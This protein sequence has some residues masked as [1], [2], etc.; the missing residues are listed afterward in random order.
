MKI[1][2]SKHKIKSIPTSKIDTDLNIP[3]AY[4]SVD[5]SKY[6]IDK[7][8]DPKFSTNSK[9]IL[10]PEQELDNTDFLLFNEFEEVVNKNNLFVSSNNKYTFYPSNTVKFSPRK[11]LWS[12]TVKKNL[13]YSISTTYNIKIGY[14]ANDTL[15]RNLITTFMN[16]SERNMLVY[17]NIKINS[18][19][20]QYDT[21]DVIDDSDADIMFIKSHNCKHYDTNNAVEID[22]N[23]FL[24]HHTNIWFGCEDAVALQE[25]YKMLMATVPYEFKISEPLVS[26]NGNI[27]SSY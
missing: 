11:F 1:Y 13:Q 2:P 21:F 24:D 19:D 7:I 4:V 25:S 3:L 27:E 8:I 15:N 22:I 20:K 23:G 26:E 12:A 16:P 18:N 14:K 5:Y 6:N 17:S 10:Y 9:T